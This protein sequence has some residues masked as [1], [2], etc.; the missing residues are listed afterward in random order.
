MSDVIPCRTS[1]IKI[2][3]SIK[4]QQPHLAAS[5]SPSP[6]WGGGSA[7]ESP[8][9]TALEARER[10]SSFPLGQGQRAHPHTRALKETAGEAL[11][12]R[13]NLEREKDISEWPFFN[14]NLYLIIVPNQKLLVIQI[15]HNAITPIYDSCFNMHW[16]KL[17]LSHKY[18]TNYT[19]SGKKKLQQL[20]KCSKI[21]T[22]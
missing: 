1:I 19:S 16:N 17:Y 8:S 4:K 6:S 5:D 22:F 3:F 2:M 11:P 13:N 15:L 12:A 14:K 7:V 9:A 18:L 10:F 21:S 20:R